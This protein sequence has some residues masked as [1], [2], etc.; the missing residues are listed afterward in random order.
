[1]NKQIF[2]LHMIPVAPHDHVQLTL[3][4]DAD[5]FWFLFW[6]HVPVFHDRNTLRF[7]FLNVILFIVISWDKTVYILT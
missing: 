2:V 4:L 5:L 1:M 6:I 7:W 3:C